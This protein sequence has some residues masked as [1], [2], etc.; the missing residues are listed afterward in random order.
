MRFL[1]VG[2]VYGHIKLVDFYAKQFNCDAVLSTGNL[3][4]FYPNETKHRVFPVYGGRLSDFKDFLL[5]REELSVPIITVRGKWDSYRFSEN[6]EGKSDLLKNFLLLPN[7]DKAQFNQFVVSGIGGLYTAGR[8]QQK[9]GSYKYCFH[10]DYNKLI[11]TVSDI[12]VMHTLIGGGVTAK[13]VL[14]NNYIYNLIDQTKVKYIFLGNSDYHA[15]C[16]DVGGAN[17]V[18]CPG[19]AK[20]F[21][22]LDTED[23]SLYYNQHLYTDRE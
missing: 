5:G 8:F 18:V 9:T 23:W 15:F 20:G 7:G 21:H 16:A 2:T 12:I 6:S 3:G 14:F 10:T 4:L 17:F 22:I 13:R 11:S 19:I 1:V